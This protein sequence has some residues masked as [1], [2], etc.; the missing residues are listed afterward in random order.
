MS[1]R[2]KLIWTGAIAALIVTGILVRSPLG[3]TRPDLAAWFSFD[4]GP[5]AFSHKYTSGRVGPFTVGDTS[6]AT[7]DRLSS[8]HLLAEDIPQIQGKLPRWRLSLP[9]RT[10]GYVTYTIMFAGGRIT[11]IN[12]YYSMFAGL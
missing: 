7:I 10:G 5:L 4:D 11:S 3:R 6:A 12:A 9:A 2:G 1:R 8:Q